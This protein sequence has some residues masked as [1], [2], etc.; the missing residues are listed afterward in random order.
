MV[1]IILIAAFLLIISSLGTALY[2]L[3][4]NKT[5]GLSPKVAKALTVRIGLS[6]LLFLLLFVLVATGVVKPHGIGSRMHSQST[7]PGQNAK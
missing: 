7:K 2:H 4:N 6:V 1:K 3:V 5:G